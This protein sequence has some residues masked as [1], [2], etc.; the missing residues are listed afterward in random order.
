MCV[1][2]ELSLHWAKKPP[3]EKQWETNSCLPN[4][5]LFSCSCLGSRQYTVDMSN[6]ISGNTGQD[7]WE[8]TWLHDYSKWAVLSYSSVLTAWAVTPVFQ[9]IF[10]SAYLHSVLWGGS[11]ITF[12]NTCILLSHI[13]QLYWCAVWN[14]TCTATHGLAEAGVPFP[15]SSQMASV[16]N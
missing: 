12:T 5:D 8:S 11:Q 9:S 1:R 7:K 2:L 14:I 4:T 13:N 6:V 10:T 16:R 3:T 15:L